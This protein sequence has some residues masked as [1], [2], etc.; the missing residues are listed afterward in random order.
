MPVTID[1]TNG[2]TTPNA[3]VSTNLSV[4]GGSVQPLTQGSSVATTSGTT[5]DLNTAIPSWV[6]R[7]T[8]V[9]NGVS[10]TG[11][12]HSIIQIGSGS[13]TTSGYSSTAAYAG[14]ANQAGVASATNG[15]AAHGGSST[16]A[17]TGTMTILNAGGNLWVAS[18]SG[19]LN[20]SIGVMGGGSVT[21]SGTLDRIRITTAN[22]TDSF[23]AGSVNIFFE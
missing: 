12:S 20:S 22:G 18:H 17:L 21:L 16:N 13:Y 2:I 3:T 1:G 19:S 4:A 6:K 14:T 15:F 23:D 7:I 9:Y 5:L 11:S 8:V 10:L